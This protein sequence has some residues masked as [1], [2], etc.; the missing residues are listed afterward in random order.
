MSP[1]P[2]VATLRRHLCW[3]LLV[4]PGYQPLLGPPVA[5]AP[6]PAF[7]QIFNYIPD[8]LL[9]LMYLRRMAVEKGTVKLN[10]VFFEW[11]VLAPVSFEVWLYC[12]VTTDVMS[13]FSLASYRIVFSA[14]PQEE[15]LHLTWWLNLSCWPFFKVC[16]I[17]GLVKIPMTKTTVS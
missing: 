6:T 2:T 3:W 12:V 4:L 11:N 10:N 1:R 14:S 13:S 15:L 5:T 17:T 7:G 8:L 16:K 9:V